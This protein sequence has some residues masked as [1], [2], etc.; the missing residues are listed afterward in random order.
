MTKYF[1]L[2]FLSLFGSMQRQDAYGV[3]TSPVTLDPAVNQ[4]SWEGWGTSLA[5]WAH[6][7]G[8]RDDLADLIFTTKTVT[9]EDQTLPGLGL[10]IVRYNAGACSWNEIDGREMA[11]SKIIQP[12]RQMEGFWL[13]GKSEDPES[14]SWNW[15]VD[16]NQRAMMLKARDRGADRFELFSNSPMWWMCV[17]DNPSGP[18]NA[19][20][21]NLS[22]QNEKA[23]AIYLATIA[24]YAKDHWGITFTHVEPFNEPLANWWFADCKQEGCPFSVAAQARVLQLLRAELDSRG[25]QDMPVAASDDNAYAEA[26]SNWNSFDAATKAVVAEINVHGYQNTARDLLYRAAKADGK[27][28]WNSEYGGADSSGLDLARNINL[29]F[30]NLHPSAWCYWQPLDGKGW[31][32]LPTDLGGKKIEA[33]NP[34]YFVLAQYSRHIRPGMTILDSGTPNTIAAYDPT[35]K[36]LVIAT[37]NDG[38]SRTLSYDLSKFASVEGPITRWITE[39]LGKTRY[40]AHSDINLVGKQFDC[41]F[42]AQSIQTFEVENVTT[43]VGA[44]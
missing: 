3:E 38:A 32:L 23:F 37:L 12:Y 8:D 10:N 1:L 2:I 24:R 21:D 43:T 35:A 30:Q 15:T 42:P 27:R 16:A 14:P 28:L 4:G 11:A 17:N 36:K 34:N 33:A 9:V 39:P 5:W 13:D 22:P 18:A 31:G 44:D 25:L 7:F 41:A 19:V 6:V 29:D 26:V 20:D 40:A